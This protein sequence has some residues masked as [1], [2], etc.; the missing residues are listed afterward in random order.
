VGRVAVKG[1]AGMGKKGAKE[2]GVGVPGAVAVMVA[3]GFGVGMLAGWSWFEWLSW[4]LGGSILRLGR[5]IN[6]RKT[7]LRVPVKGGGEK[8]VL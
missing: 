3:G 4:S 5:W 6:L 1:A 8:G 2:V 7:L